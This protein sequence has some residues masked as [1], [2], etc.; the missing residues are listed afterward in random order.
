MK[1]IAMLATALQLIVGILAAGASPAL[2]QDGFQALLEADVSAVEAKLQL[3][4]NEKTQVDAILQDGVNKRLAVLTSLGVTYGQRPSFGT[5]LKLRSQMDD[6]RTEQQTALA[7]ILSES[8]MF[9]VDQ[10]A[11]DSEQKFRAVLL[12]S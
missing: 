8:Q 1:R 4:G 2:A 6:I 12:G 3:A 7:K 5:L 11:N 10:M 9:V